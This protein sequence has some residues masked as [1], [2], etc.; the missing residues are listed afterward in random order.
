MGTEETPSI[1]A[2]LVESE[3][4][5]VEE[6]IA[7]DSS[8]DENKT[9]DEATVMQE[10]LVEPELKTL[11]EVIAKDITIEENKTTKETSDMLDNLVEA[12]K[13]TLDVET[14]IITE[15]EEKEVGEDTSM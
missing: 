9:T 10:N 8:L 3:Q 13:N 6:V 11:G 14:N 4:S 15:R 1:E 12:D 2:N 7:K 5:V